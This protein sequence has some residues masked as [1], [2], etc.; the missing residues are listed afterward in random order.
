MAKTIRLNRYTVSKKKTGADLFQQPF[1]TNTRSPWDAIVGSA[2]QVTSGLATHTSLTAALAAVPALD[3]NI[4][5]LR[6]TYLENIVVTKRVNIQ[7]QGYG[8]QLNGTFEM[9]SLASHSVIEK[10]NFLS[11]ITL[12][13]GSTGIF[14]RSF[15]QSAGQTLLDSGLG[16]SKLG[17]VG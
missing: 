7:G 6:G 1:T 3:G 8:T 9:Q 10:M 15:Y 17:A 13:T 14:L 2:F 4:L 5:V 12:D 11:S 16:N